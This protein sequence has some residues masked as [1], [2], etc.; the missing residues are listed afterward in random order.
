MQAFALR[1]YLAALGFV[2]SAFF[3]AGIG[4]AG[5]GR[6][7]AVTTCCA[8]ASACVGYRFGRMVQ[9]AMW[10]VRRQPAP[11]PASLAAFLSAAYRAK[12][13]AR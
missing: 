1:F 2:V 9:H 12:R 13:A 6:A 8:L 3:G 4:A 10:Q 7:M 5:A 11:P